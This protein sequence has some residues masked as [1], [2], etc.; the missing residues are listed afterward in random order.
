MQLQPSADQLQMVETFGRFF[1]DECSM[2]RLRAALPL[3]FDPVMWRK[4]AELG[5][6]GVRVS[7]SGGGVDLGLLDAILLLEEAGRTLVSGP[8][9]ESIVALRLLD[10]FG[11]QEDM[12]ASA[13]AG[14]S[15]VTLALHD[16]SV[17]SEQLVAGGAVADAVIA[18]DTDDIV[19]V[20]APSAVAE[21]T[22]GAGAVA[23][24]SLASGERILLGSGRAAVA[25]FEAALEEWKLLAAA[26]LT[27]LS[28]EALRLASAYASERRQF[29]KP[30]GA[31]QA[32]SHPLASLSVDVDA[33]RLLIWNA[34]RDIADS[35]PVAAAEVP[36]ALWWACDV[37][38][39]TVAQA[40]HTFGGYGLTLEYDIHLYNLRAKAWPLILGDPDLL[41]HEAGRRRYGGETAS[42]P[43]PGELD[44]EF[45]LGAGAE[46]LANETREFFRRTLTPELQARAHFSFKGHVPEVHCALASAGL[47]FPT[48]PRRL[49]GRNADLY[50]E[51]ASLRVWREFG[52]S[53]NFQGTVNM[54]GA[55]IDMFGSPELKREVLARFATGDAVCSLGFSEPDSGSDVFA[56]KTRAVR[57]GDEW[58]IDGQKMFTSG[59]ERA[60]YVLLLARTDPEAP[61]H[62]GLTM[63]I[64]PLKADGVSVQPVHTFQDELTN[65]T[66]YD[67][68]RIP[69]SYRLGDVGGGVK[70]MAASLEMEH[71]MSFSDVHRRLLHAA[72]RLCLDRNGTVGSARVQARLAKVAARVRAS[73]LLF[74]RAMWAAEQKLPNMAYG[75]ASKLFSS[76]MFRADAADL[77]DLTAPESLAVASSDAATVNLAYRHSQV[78][79]VYGGASEIHRSI[80]AERQLGLPRSR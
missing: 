19:L 57:H 72:E 20:R 43:D 7:E 78:T 24:M 40:L 23:R 38:G 80:I 13:L 29:G 35:S 60:D 1:D 58:V 26:A 25:K 70:V 75:P 59:A 46:A 37:A 61:K 14:D 65:I 28:R 36:T 63:F 11:G 8:V 34:V 32:I 3:G 54:A 41:L 2:A 79:T 18:R 6:V 22:L 51:E 9:A 71:G 42:L 53:T 62:S 69:D 67:G 49:G 64:V 15:V 5:G 30:I 39:R 50:E 73:E 74:C 55:M 33:G 68:V 44:I 48:W 17:H 76:E 45:S 27:G 77:L 21:P 16:L 10:Q 56:A 31:F 52:W 12:L 66:F 4:F 47:L